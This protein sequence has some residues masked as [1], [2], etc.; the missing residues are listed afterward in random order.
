MQ[1][2]YTVGTQDYIVNH[3]RI[4]GFKTENLFE[5]G[6]WNRSGIKLE[7]EGE[8]FLSTTNAAT[9][10]ENV[11]NGMNTPRGS[12]SIAWDG[13]ASYTNIASSNTD[14]RN[15][16]M[17]NVSVIE[18]VGLK[19]QSVLKVK[20]QFSWFECAEYA[21]QRFELTQ[22]SEVDQSGFAKLHREGVLVLSSQIP[23]P[24]TKKF[25]KYVNSTSYPWLPNPFGLGI[26]T[27]GGACPDLYRRIVCGQ[28]PP[29]YH[30]VSQQYGMDPSLTTLIFATEDQ[31]H[32]RD[33]PNPALVGD[34]SFKYQRSLQNMLGKKTFHGHMEGDTN[35]NP[36]DLLNILFDACQSR[37][38]FF[39]KTAGGSYDL[40][41]SIQVSEPNLYSRNRVEL[42]VEAM[43]TDDNIVQ[44]GVVQMVFSKLHTPIAGHATWQAKI[45]DAYAPNEFIV[46][47][48]DHLKRMLCGS[49]QSAADLVIVSDPTVL[50]TDVFITSANNLEPVSVPT[51]T[52]VPD[53]GGT[54]RDAMLKDGVV[55]NHQAV[56][57]R[58]IKS[59]GI[60]FIQTIGGKQFPYQSE[61]PI[62]EEHQEMTL[63][64]RDKNPP[65]PWQDVTDAYILKNSSYVVTST[66]RDA[67]G[68]YMY[69]IKA[70]R[71]VQIQT[72]NSVN[73][74][75][76]E[77]GFQCKTYS[78]DSLKSP[79]SPYQ[80][81]DNTYS[82]QHDFAKD[83]AG[84]KDKWFGNGAT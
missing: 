77:V 19:S 72:T 30:R 45:P 68:R 14:A 48:L 44:W 5:N 75:V 16:P 82:T 56:T 34:A 6:A 66:S 67:S 12:I 59:T 74:E 24:S 18:M 65:I 35:T 79:R 53:N 20:F 49:V 25:A 84:T 2:K 26:T 43:G 38:S 13:D 46:G 62:V 42:E 17:A 69:G 83:G 58:F 50:K 31:M 4:T 9:T 41:Q 47:N 73:T 70:E 11:T 63:F 7:M 40:I 36:S 52:A 32:F 10:I 76:T 29:L 37:I 51:P 61:L 22:R 28:P 33:L 54:E 55:Y 60:S 64:C 23:Q 3:S 80:L 8:G 71:V 1:L 39:P 78:P 27:D 15:G 21:I 81:A 57:G